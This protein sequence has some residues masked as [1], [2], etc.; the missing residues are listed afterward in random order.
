[1]VQVLCDSIII[2]KRCLRGPHRQWRTVKDASQ[3]PWA[4]CHRVV[5]I[6]QVTIGDATKPLASR[7]WENWMPFGTEASEAEVVDVAWARV[8]L[9]D[10]LAAGKAA[11]TWKLS[12][13][14]KLGQVRW[15]RAYSVCTLYEGRQ[16]QHVWT[17]AR[18]LRSL[19]GRSI[20]ADI[21]CAAQSTTSSIT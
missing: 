13:P 6:P 7:I 20:S 12:R 1:M 14:D 3:A 18:Q 10:I 5:A 2:A 11:G 16:Q 21:S 17:F 15:S 4:P 8:P 9:A 19:S